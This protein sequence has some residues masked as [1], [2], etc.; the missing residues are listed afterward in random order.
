MQ[1]QNLRDDVRFLIFKDT[2]ATTA[3]SN[4][5]IDRNI[6]QWYRTI[7]SWI[8]GSNGEW[9]VFGEYATANIV[10]DQREY[11]LPTDILRLNEVYIKGTTAGTYLKA[12]QRDIINV[13]DYPEDYHPAT[14]EFDLIDNSLFI[15][16]PESSITN[17]TAGIKIYYQT[18]L[19]ELTSTDKP[20]LADVFIRALVY[21]AVFDYLLAEEQSKAK[22]FATLLGIDQPLVD[23]GLKK[24]IKEHYANR[25][26]TKQTTL[27]P[28]EEN[29]Y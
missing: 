12:T 3:Y 21:G 9:Q 27:T 26:Q 7:L 20:N 5:D 14:P 19:T 1:L 16:L 15:Y 17:V 18:E 4:T 29:L 6:N 25:A 24:D 2:T 23:A 11:I 28:A 13:E 22:T 10:A 8:L